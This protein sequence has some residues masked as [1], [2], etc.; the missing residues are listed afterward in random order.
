MLGQRTSYVISENSS[1]H[2]PDCTLPSAQVEDFLWF[3]LDRHFFQHQDPMFVRQ[4]VSFC[5]LVYPVPTAFVFDTFI[6][7]FFFL[8]PNI[9]KDKAGF[10]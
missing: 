10:G 7:V 5:H 8:S 6:K 2:S 4:F 3:P 1:V 9:F